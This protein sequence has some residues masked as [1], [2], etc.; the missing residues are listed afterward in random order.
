MR[1]TFSKE[2]E[3]FREEVR[4]WLD[5]NLSGKFLKT[6]YRGGP[7]DETAFIDERKEWETVLADGGWTCIGWPV[8]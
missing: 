5:K 2:D 8:D 3:L 1:L 6:K 4:S 7:G